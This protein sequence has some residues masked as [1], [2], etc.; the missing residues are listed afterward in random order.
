MRATTLTGLAAA[1][2]LV[3][4][5]DSGGS[6]NSA[7]DANSISEDPYG[8]TGAPGAD[9]TDNGV[10]DGANGMADTDTGAATNEAGAS[11]NH[12]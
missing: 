5:G 1:L 10:T 9:L 8:A 3:G 6:D 12:Q 11:S 2:L 4:C 7:A